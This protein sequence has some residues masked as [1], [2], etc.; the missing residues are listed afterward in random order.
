[1]PN[2]ERRKAQ[3]LLN[4]AQRGVIDH[5]HQG[6]YD[7]TD[8]LRVWAARLDGAK[9]REVLFKCNEICQAL[10]ANM[11]V[12]VTGV[13]DPSVPDRAAIN[14]GVYNLL[15][16]CQPIYHALRSK[17]S[18]TEA[19]D[20]F[21]AAQAT[22]DRLKKRDAAYDKDRKE[23]GGWVCEKPKRKT[24]KT[25]RAGYAGKRVKLDAKAF[26]AFQADNKRKEENFK[27]NPYEYT[28]QTTEDDEEAFFDYQKK[29]KKKSAAATRRKRKALKEE[30][31]P[32]PPELEMSVRANNEKKYHVQSHLFQYAPKGMKNRWTTKEKAMEL[33]EL[34]VA[35]RPVG[36]GCEAK[37]AA[38]TQKGYPRGVSPDP[39]G[40]GYWAML[41]PKKR[42]IVTL[43]APGG[44]YFFDTAKAAG[45]AVEKY[46]AAGSPTKKS[47]PLYDTLVYSVRRKK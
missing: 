37:Q 23:N 17:G 44:G 8:R 34:C 43:K 3:Q 22:W 36:M 39:D 6:L 46:E 42:T 31:E 18:L 11:E 47:D 29:A 40:G 5:G 45:E 28:N 38:R 19:C 7:V 30:E 1:M 35:N 41:T 26:A 13:R 9:R 15:R 14:E 21:D 25:G 27:Q 33:A 10:D 12:F 16:D 20:E 32:T 2:R 4:S 24:T